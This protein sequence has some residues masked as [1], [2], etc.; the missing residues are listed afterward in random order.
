MLAYLKNTVIYND[1]IQPAQYVV[2]DIFLT[3]CFHCDRGLYLERFGFSL[4]VRTFFFFLILS[5]QVSIP[6]DSFHCIHF[7]AFNLTLMTKN[8]PLPV[9]RMYLYVVTWCARISSSR[10]ESRCYDNSG[11]P[12]L[13]SLQVTAVTV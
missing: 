1:G 7:P 9:C 13:K 4:P 6:L 12:N 2:R 3:R 10:Q 5:L 11:P 8:V